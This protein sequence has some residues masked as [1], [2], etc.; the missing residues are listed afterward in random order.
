MNRTVSVVILFCGVYVQSM[1]YRSITCSFPWGMA[2]QL[3]TC[4]EYP[5]N[6]ISMSMYLFV[7][8]Q[9]SEDSAP[10][11][12]ELVEQVIEQ[13]VSGTHCRSNL[14]MGSEF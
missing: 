1:A 10:T 8:S 14:T 3:R 5:T 2:L 11:F 7:H 9:K 4:E 6:Y 13:L 12:R